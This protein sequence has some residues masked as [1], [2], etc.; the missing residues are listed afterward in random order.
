MDGQRIIWT[1]AG[2][3]TALYEMGRQVNHLPC[4][5]PVYNVF[6]VDSMNINRRGSLSSLCL[7]L[8]L[9]SAGAF[10][11]S[12]KWEIGYFSEGISVYA[13]EG[14]VCVGFHIPS[15][16]LHPLG[17]PGWHFRD[18]SPDRPWLV[19]LMRN[20]VRW[21]PY[22]RRVGGTVFVV[23]ALW[24]PLVAGL[25]PW[26]FRLWHRARRKPGHCR[27]CDYDLTGNVSGKCPE[28][29]TPIPESRRYGEDGV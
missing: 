22:V 28:C 12:V 19:R 8:S 1:Y 5:T 25:T 16:V 11:L 10:V 18:P 29:G 26:L 15:E 3:Q 9:V 23:V 2:R 27:F 21:L 6:D 13:I 4:A 24:I 20:D 14:A 7:L 17:G